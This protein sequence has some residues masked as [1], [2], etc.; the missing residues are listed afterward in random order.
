LIAADLLR[1]F[2]S[3]HVEPLRRRE[4]TMWR[5]LGPNSP[6]RPFSAE[7]GDMEVDT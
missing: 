2:I 7:L 1:T 4:V 3:Y 6:D 5:Y